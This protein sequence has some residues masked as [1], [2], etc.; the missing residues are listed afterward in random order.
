MQIQVSMN[1]KYWQASVYTNNVSVEKDKKTGIVTGF[2][3]NIQEFSVLDF[4][5]PDPQFPE[6]MNLLNDFTGDFFA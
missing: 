5:L 1:Y 3:D 2:V 6:G 4:S